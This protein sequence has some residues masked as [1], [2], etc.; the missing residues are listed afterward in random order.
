[1]S[2]INHSIT[3]EDVGVFERES[4]TQV[5]NDQ[6]DIN[7]HIVG[8]PLENFDS[9]EIVHNLLENNTDESFENGNISNNNTKANESAV[10]NFSKL[11]HNDSYINNDE[12]E[13]FIDENSDTPETDEKL[14]DYFNPDDL[15][16][17]TSNENIEFKNEKLCQFPLSRIKSIV[18]TD[19]DVTVINA[20]C[21]FLIAKA[22]VSFCN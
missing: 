14:V 16:N 9:D 11:Y 7:N 12:N 5:N 21:V 13:K 8:V 1:M 15:V 19:P 22:S 18:K 17:N 2:D 10:N 4:E 6:A 20:E 3:K